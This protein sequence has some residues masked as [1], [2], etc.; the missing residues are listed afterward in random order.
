MPSCPQRIEVT[1]FQPPSL[2]RLKLETTGVFT[3]Q[4]T[5][6]LTSVGSATRLDIESQYEFG[7]WF[8]K[9]MSPVI[10]PAARKKMIDDLGRL[11]GI[12]ERH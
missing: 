12:L 3:G 9:L 7:M 10:M 2:L 4:Q 11:K 8:A 5:Y 6:R 1:D